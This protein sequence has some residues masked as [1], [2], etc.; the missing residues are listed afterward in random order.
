MSWK[1]IVKDYLTFSYKERIGII[2]VL[3]ISLIVI[4]LPSYFLNQNNSEQT[5]ID[6]TWMGAM[7]KLEHKEIS[8]GQPASEEN[9]IDLAALQYDRSENNNYDDQQTERLFYFDP[10]TISKKEWQQL[11]V[12]DKTIRVIQNYLS[13]GGRFKTPSDL[14]RIYGLRK[15]EFERLVPFVKISG[16]FK[17]TGDGIIINKNEA[18]QTKYLRKTSGKKFIDINTADTS[19]FIELYGIGSKLA[20]RII[21]FRD[22]LGGFYS[23]DQV[24]ETFGLPDSTFQKIKQYLTIQNQTIKKININSANVEELKTHPYIRY[25][26]AN[27]IVAYR[28]AHGSFS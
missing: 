11:G 16:D 13:K 2:T 25:N 5:T 17:K 4:F 23:V 1:D 19:D 20:A 24:G 3:I 10:N 26:L 12:R 14:Q 21:N 28:S 8:N 27:P 18:E 9:D 15:N 6:T 22:K 7:Q